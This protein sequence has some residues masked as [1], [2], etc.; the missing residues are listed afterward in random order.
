MKKNRYLVL[1]AALLAVFAIVPPPALAADQLLVIDTNH[2]YAGMELTYGQGYAPQ[3][4][5]EEA[6]IRMPL[7]VS[8]IYK[9]S[10]QGDSITVTPDLGAKEQSPFIWG[11]YSQSVTLKEYAVQ[12]EQ[13]NQAIQ[14]AYYI[15]LHLPLKTGRINGKYPIDLQI[16]YL[17]EEGLSLQQSFTAYVEIRDG[18]DPA[19][20]NGVRQSAHSQM[21]I[22]N[23]EVEPAVAPA[24]TTF[25]VDFT[26]QN[27]SQSGAAQ[28][29][30][31]T[32]N[33]EGDD[34]KLRGSTGT[35]FISRI[36]K[37]CSQICHIELDVQNTAKSGMHRVFLNIAYTDENGQAS[38]LACEIP[39][40]VR[41]P[42][43]LKYGQPSVPA[44]VFAGNTIVASLLIG[45]NGMD[46]LYDMTVSLVSD[47][48]I[49]TAD[50]FLGN[51]ESGAHK[52]AS[53]L[54]KATGEP[55]SAEGKF[56]VAYQD[57]NGMQYSEEVPFTSI[58]VPQTTVFWGI[59][60]LWA[61]IAAVVVA[62]IAGIA[63]YLICRKTKTD[64]PE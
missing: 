61:A 35:I 57:E 34:I 2:V 5:A 32:Y 12:D 17:N 63:V 52:T 19:L 40:T 26:M 50:T 33:S 31:V 59:P 20:D 6:V 4:G 13:N 28:N 62:A 51:M 7:V 14:K 46:T 56:V 45:N 37:G 39:V 38:N 54:A 21:V 25:G 58:I 18:A 64:R 36:E 49:S 53:I 42:V 48:F 11:D 15:V 3:T 47:G 23:Y 27:N 9:G 41:Q 44:K 8:E 16:G 22:S 30:M 1:A 43:Q 60:R 24:G 29:I 55:R 10:V